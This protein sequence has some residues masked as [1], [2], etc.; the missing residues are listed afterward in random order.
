MS[1]KFISLPNGQSGPL[2][3]AENATNGSTESFRLV[4]VVCIE[5]AIFDSHLICKR[6]T[7]AKM[8]ASSFG[9][10]FHHPRKERVKKNDEYITVL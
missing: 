1:E 9:G 10:S 3:E 6:G 7:R 4:I 8:N 2:G 5:Y